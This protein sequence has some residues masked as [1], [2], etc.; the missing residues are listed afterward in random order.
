MIDA[1]HQWNHLVLGFLLLENFSLS[2]QSLYYIQACSHFPFLLELILVIC[3]FLGIGP[4]HQGCPPCRHTA[5][6]R[7]WLCIKSLGRVRLFA[8]PWTAAL[9][10]PLSVG[11]SREECWSRVP[12]PF[13]RGSSWPRD[14]TLTSWVSCNGRQILYLLAPLGKPICRRCV[15]NSLSRV[16]LCDPMGLYSPWSSPGQ[17]TRGGSLSL[18]QLIFPLQESNRS[19]LHCSWILYQLS[20]QGSP[21]FHNPFNFCKVTFPLS[22]LISTGGI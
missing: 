3:V 17:N 9:Q 13:S 2:I 5:A 22:F 18:C 8:T 4:F 14:W 21:L 16:W 1:F 15:W 20:Y 11:F 6:H 10:A 19:L 12:F 7:Q